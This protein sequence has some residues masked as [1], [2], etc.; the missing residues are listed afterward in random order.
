MTD[1]LLFTAV[2]QLNRTGSVRDESQGILVARLNL[3]AGNRSQ[4]LSDFS[5]SLKLFERGISHLPNAHWGK[6]YDLSLA[7]YNSTA[8]SACA[9]NHTEKVTYLYEQIL[10][11]SRSFDDRLPCECPT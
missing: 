5:T 1:E 4:N 9:L 3:Q 10:A 2:N 11:N 6:Q 8:S 7:L